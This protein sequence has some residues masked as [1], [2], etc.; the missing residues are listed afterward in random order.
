MSPE[1]IIQAGK[2]FRIPSGD[3][4]SQQVPSSAS[5]GS[6]SLSA[7]RVRN[8]LAGSQGSLFPSHGVP[9]CLLLEKEEGKELSLFSLSSAYFK[10]GLKN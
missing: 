1:H 3:F 10:A 9:V 7:K 2:A 5:G 8:A 6:D 4:H